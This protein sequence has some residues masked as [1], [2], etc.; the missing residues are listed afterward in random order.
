VRCQ[1]FAAAALQAVDATLAANRRDDG[2][3]H[4][5]NLLTLAPDSAAVGH[6]QLMLEG[7]VAALSS[8]LLDAS[9]ASALLAALRRSALYRDD[10]R[11]Y[12]LYPD[13]PIVP[14][15]ERNV[16]PAGW[17]TRA[18]LLAMPATAGCPPIVGVDG[19]GRA[20]FNADLTNERD[21]RDLLDRIA[22]DPDRQVVVNRDRDAILTLWEEVFHHHAFTGRSGAMFAFE[23]LGSIYWHMIAKLLLSVQ[24]LH[25]REFRRDPG[26]AAARQLADDYA[27]IRLGLGF[28]KDARTYG[29]FPTDPY[30][31]T[32]RHRGAQQPGMTGQVKEEILTRLGELGVFVSGGLVS[33]EPALL[34]RAE[35]FDCPHCFEY[36][37]IGGTVRTW[38]LGPQTLAFTLCQVPVCYLLGGQPSITV[39]W[40]DGTTTTHAGSVLPPAPSRELFARSGL[41][42]RLI[43]TLS[44]DRIPL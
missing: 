21:L 23:G 42:R 13:K 29:A 44:N 1:Q 38:Q 35:F 22:R 26:S 18:P 19:D 37:D 8:G 16:L 25:T 15:L 39:E 43:V 4:S 2:M 5:Y 10:Q 32:P 3:F 14:F 11:S 28:T 6:L 24:E 36:I 17:K 34:N 7:Q 12:L 33:F 31:H 40:D 30:S 20:R 9:Q 27:A 41:I